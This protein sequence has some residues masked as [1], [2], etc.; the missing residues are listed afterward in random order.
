MVNVDKLDQ[1]RM[2][3]IWITAED[4]LAR[5]KVRPQT[6]YAYVSRGLVEQRARDGDSRRSLYRAADI[7]ALAQRKARGRRTAD[8]ARQA[9]AWGEPV[10]ASAVSTV[11]RGRLYYRGQDAARLAQTATLE[12]VAQLLWDAGDRLPSPTEAPVTG[13]A[14]GVKTRAFAYLADRA[15]SDPPVLGRATPALLRDAASVLDGMAHAVAG[16]AGKGSAHARL[17]RAWSAGDEGADLIRRTLVLVADHELNASTFAAR[18]A[19][20]TAASLAASALAGL[21][22]LSGPLHGGH[23]AQVRAFLDEAQTKGAANAVRDRLDQGSPIPGFGHALYPEGDPRFTT[24]AAA[25][26]LPPQDAEVIAVVQEQT[27]QA[28]NIDF[29]LCAMSQA[30]GFPADAP[31]AMF[32]LGRTVGWLAHALEQHRTG[33]LIRPRARYVGPEPL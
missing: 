30:M 3:E 4:A 33:A 21:A 14:P 17:A 11:A 7:D 16:Q 26:I 29:A 19:A 23:F 22:A 20:S 18:V 1:Y 24:L 8:V 12:E 32:A 13:A 27:G 28:A 10:L 2:S 6:L 15:S 31:F 25:F 5:L 9:I